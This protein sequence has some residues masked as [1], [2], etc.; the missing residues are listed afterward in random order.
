MDIT[1]LLHCP[2]CHRLIFS[3]LEQIEL[4]SLEENIRI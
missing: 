4:A 1:G 3:T 2:V